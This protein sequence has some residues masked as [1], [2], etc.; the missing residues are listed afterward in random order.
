[1]ILFIVVPFVVRAQFM[2]EVYDDTTQGYAIGVFGRYQMASNALSAS[3]LNAIFTGSDL[4]RE[5][6]DGV[7]SRLS[8]QNRLGLD[9][10]YGLYVRHLSDS[11][12]GVGWFIRIANRYHAN[13]S[14]SRD[15]L[16]LAMFGNR[17][18]AGETADLGDLSFNYLQYKQFELGIL[19]RWQLSRT[20]LFFGFGLSVLT[21]N[22]TATAEIPE[23]TLFTDA[24]GEYLD[25]EVHGTL[26]TSSIA[27]TQYFAANGW[28]FSAAAHLGMTGDRFGW[29]IQLDDLG[30]ISWGKRLRHHDIDTVARFEGPEIDLFATDPFAAVNFDTIAARVVTSREGD[31]FITAI[32]GSVRIEG[33]YGLNDNGWRLYLGVH[34]RFAADYFPL[35]YLGTSAPLPKQFYIDGRFGWGGFG[36]WNIGLELRKRFGKHVAVRLGSYNIEGYLM[37]GVATGQ[38]AYVGLSGYF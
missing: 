4:S 16:N 8:D 36:S 23:A 32:P 14:L 22:Q 6:R 13:A 7:A 12:H 2:H 18:F 37:P 35:I 38:S 21:G 19:K 25:A 3:M 33:S 1:M 24:D 30:M 9:G 28:G 27:S 34:Q 20:S 11:A 26:R 31:S 10:D 15:L 17:Q 29:T 5:M